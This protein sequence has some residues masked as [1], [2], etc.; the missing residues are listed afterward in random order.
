MIDKVVSSTIEAVAG[1]GNG[2]KL[3]ISG[4]GNAGVPLQLIDAVVSRGTR[5]LTIVSNNAGTGDEGVAA[6]LRAGAV[7]KIVCSFPRGERGSWFEQ[8]YTQGRIELELVP[9]G[10]LTERIRAG[11]SGIRGFYTKVGLGTQFA[12]GKTIRRFDGEDFV[13][14]EAI[15]A[16]FAL[17]RA[18]FAD[19]WGNLTYS[20]SARNFGPTMAAA[21]RVT[22]AQVDEVVPLGNLD[23][24]SIV[25]PSIYVDRIVVCN[26]IRS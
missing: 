7:K 19:R 8:L 6:L 13:L 24:E 9:Q 20:K 22:I 25:T 16:D 21:A 3:L 18:R 26:T 4:F 14:E 12:D 2:S 1:I 5:D 23:P 17:V 11:G 10:T 15:V